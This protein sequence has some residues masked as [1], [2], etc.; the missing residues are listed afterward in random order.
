MRNRVLNIQ[1]PG[2]YSNSNSN[3][4]VNTKNKLRT[5]IKNLYG[6]SD[7][8]LNNTEINRFVNQLNKSGSNVNS[9]KRNAYKKAYTKYMNYMTTNFAQ[10]MIKEIKQKIKPSPRC[11]SGVV[12]GGP[13]MGGI[14]RGVVGGMKAICGNPGQ[15]KCRRSNRQG[16]GTTTKYNN[17]NRS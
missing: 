3:N 13:S 5:D 16:K 17:F 14:V 11:P 15:P 7:G 12:G 9:I 6:G 10:D 8:F 4:N 1:Q 2:G